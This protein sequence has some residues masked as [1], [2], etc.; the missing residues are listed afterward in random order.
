M[1]IPQSSQAG[2]R[3]QVILEE[4]ECSEQQSL[5]L[6]NCRLELEVL[7]YASRPVPMPFGMTSPLSL[8]RRLSRLAK[9]LRWA[10][11]S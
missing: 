8:F 5:W 6:R 10:A 3:R 9:T 7:L 11:H 1:R 2:F 4:L